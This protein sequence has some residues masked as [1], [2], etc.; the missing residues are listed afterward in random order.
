MS[1]PSPGVLRVHN[2]LTNRVEPVIPADPAR[3][4]FYTCGPTVYDDAH[5]GNFRPFLA[6]DLLRR[7]IESPL[8][9]PRDRS[10]APPRRPERQVVH[11]MNITDVG[12]MTD[13]DV[14]DG[15]G[16]DKWPSPANDSPKPK[17]RQPPLASTS[18]RAT[19]APS[20]AFYAER[21][22]DD[23]RKLRAQ[24]RDRRRASDPHAHARHRPHR[25]YDRR[26]RMPRRTRVRL[27]PRQ[28]WRGAAVY[29]D[30]QKRS[31]TANS[32]ATLRQPPRRRRRTRLRRAPGRQTTP[33]TSSS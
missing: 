23:A 22:L 30:V 1:D 4:T 12:H 11:V 10:R 21:F 25:A 7:W 9:T 24:G 33:P 19:P 27:R 15:A 3:V 26:R 29:F 5:I 18:T 28:P 14:A 13:D 32:P 31:A 16:E 6:A 8:C 2:T 17:S 20:P